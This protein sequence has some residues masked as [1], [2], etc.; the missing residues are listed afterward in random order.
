MNSYK[1]KNKKGFTYIESVVF[2][3]IFSLVV[4]TF[5]QVF[6]L[7]TRY[8][9]NSKN[10]LGAI[11]VANEKMEI[12]RNLKYKDVGTV[13]GFISGNI[14]QTENVIENNQKY[15]VQTEVSYRDDPFDGTLDGSPDDADWEDYKIIGVTVSWDNGDADRGDVFIASQFSPP[16]LE[17]VDATDGVLS[18]NILLAEANG[19]NNGVAGFNVHIEN[20]DLGISEDRQT[21]NAGNITIIGLKQSI[22]KYKLTVSKTGYETVNTFPPYPITSYNPTDVDATVI[23]GTINNVSIVVYR[24]ADLKISAVDYL[25]NSV[26]DVHFK[27]VGGRILGTTNDQPP[28]NVYKFNKVDVTGADGTK[29]YKSVGLGQYTLGLDSSE[30]KYSIVGMNQIS[31]FSLLFGIIN[32]IK[33]KVADRL[34]TGYLVNVL[35]K[36]DNSPLNSASVELKNTS[37]NYDRTVATDNSGMAFFPTVNDTKLLPGTYDITIKA[38]GYN[39][40]TGTVTAI[41]GKL[42]SSSQTLT[43]K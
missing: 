15:K 18:I 6:S 26:S 2:L 24:V 37:L 43:A 13:G 27:L 34:V 17:S 28:L 21:D 42:I 40:Y 41:D 32:N 11:S 19:G 39:T 29:E 3:F 22:Q 1:F 33:I 38:E 4:V 16:G 35:R 8:I 10:R 9:V 7:G 30:T 23:A 25:G 12:D 36:V 31:P 14:P 5:Y 20:S